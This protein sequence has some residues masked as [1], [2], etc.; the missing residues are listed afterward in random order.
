MTAA[1][2]L[3][4]LL[5]L[6]LA[7]PALVAACG[8][9]K[10]DSISLADAAATTRQADSAR[11]TMSLKA[12]GSGLPRSM[13]VTAAGVTSMTEPRM[14]LT[15]DL[16]ALLGNAKARIVATGGEVFVQ[17]PALPGVTIPGGKQ[18]VTADLK[19]VVSAFG[20]DGSAFA[21]LFRITPSQQMAA[22]EALE[23]KGGIK[24]V[25]DE[26]IDGA[27]TTHFR[28]TLRTS[29]YLKALPAAKRKR[30]EKALRELD[31][32]PGAKKGD[33]NTATPTDIWVDEDSRVRRMSTDVRTPAQAGA[34][35]GRFLL[36]FD[37]SDFGTPLNV[38][39]PAA[40]ETFDATALLVRALRSAR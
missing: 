13:E 24:R 22:L 12:S 3:L 5:L 29:D 19:R 16:G 40:A 4:P 11:M 34:P 30:I 1:R 23:R 32:L 14:D 33:W 7:L 8:E 21:E 25:G 27:R 15:F 38:K 6:L 36:R 10:Q 18:W 35:A 20:I 26:E 31:K 28:G 17:P 37:Y 9:D 2:R 39:A